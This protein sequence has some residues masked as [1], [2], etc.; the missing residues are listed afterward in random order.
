MTKIEKRYREVIAALIV[1]AVVTAPVQATVHKG[2]CLS[3]PNGKARGGKITIGAETISFRGGGHQQSVLIS[4]ITKISGGEFA[5]RRVKGAIGWAFLA[6]VA[7]FALIGK[8]KREM[9]AVEYETTEGERGALVFQVKKR[10]G[11][12]VEADLE[13]MTGLDVEWE[14][15]RAP[16]SKGD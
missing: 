5:K 9:F 14:E 15:A 4:D 7:L 8:K 10:L 3:T 16:K 12:A 1:A 11:F 2:E 6:P 13:A